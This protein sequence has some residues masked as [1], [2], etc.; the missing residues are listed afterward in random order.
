MVKT[1][2]MQGGFCIHL[3]TF[4]QPH[5]FSLLPFCHIFPLPNSLSGNSP[6]QLTISCILPCLQFLSRHDHTCPCLAYRPLCKLCARYFFKQVFYLSVPVDV[7][8][9][10]T[11]SLA[12]QS[13]AGSWDIWTSWMTPLDIE[14]R[15]TLLLLR[16]AGLF[17]RN[18][19]CLGLIILKI[20]VKSLILLFCRCVAYL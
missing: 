8:T 20:I 2:C 12:L 7:W 17:T 13:N 6:K 9:W 14:P 10:L 1:L 3:A 19:T 11:A 4:L 18:K 16:N 5:V 15:L